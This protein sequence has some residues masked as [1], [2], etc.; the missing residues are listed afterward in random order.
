MHLFR[1]FTPASVLLALASCWTSFSPGRCD[2]DSDCPAGQ[3]CDLNPTPQGNGRCVSAPSDGGGDGPRTDSQACSACS[4]STPVCVNGTCVEC[5]TSADCVGNPTKPI[6][7]TT[8][9]SCSACLTDD[10]CV[11]KLGP[12]PGVCMA[13]QDGRC[14][15]DAETIYVLND[16]STCVATFSDQGGTVN[17]P[18]C[19]MEPLGLAVGGSRTLFLVRGPVN[20]GTWVYQT[21]AS[22]PET[23]IIGKGGAVVA[24]GAQPAFS[25]AS[26]RVY[27]RGLELSSAT[28]L[29]VTATGGT[30]RLDTVT[31][32]NC[33]QGGVLLDA[34]AFDIR[35]T[36]VVANGP[37]DVMGTVWGG[38]RV[39]NLP[40]GLPA[41]LDLLT[42]QNNRAVGLSCSS[43]VMGTGVLA[44][45]NTTVDVTA[46]C[47]VTSCAAAGP[48][49][50]A[51]G[52]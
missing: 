28:S 50:G 33:P 5:A 17:M 1:W 23:S 13:H 14:A 3:V 19:S 24:G 45:N 18:Y 12:N 32:D 37:G 31:V 43:A 34:T 8:G 10:Q 52:P 20:A 48:T 27:I 26:G 35:N 46:S 6:C 22:K 15:T 2:H 36:T 11:A 51:T 4:G 16:S 30:L 21:A 25:M 29:G 41:T 39:Q 9:H 47:G 7:D 49:C 44:T 40:S 42:I 38:I